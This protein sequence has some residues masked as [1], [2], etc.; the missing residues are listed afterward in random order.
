[1]RVGRQEPDGF[2]FRPNAVASVPSG[3]DYAAEKAANQFVI[4]DEEYP[5]HLWVNIALLV[6]Q[7]CDI[8]HGCIWP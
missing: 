7:R 4:L 6:R 2:G 8:G 3:T 1:V 5:R